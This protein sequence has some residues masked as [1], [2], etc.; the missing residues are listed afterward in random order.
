[1]L[2]CVQSESFALRKNLSSAMSPVFKRGL[3][4]ERD[5]GRGRGFTDDV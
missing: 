2:N 5:L 1:M 3:A 4:R